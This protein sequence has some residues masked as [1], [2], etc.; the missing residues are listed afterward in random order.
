MPTT[1]SSNVLSDRAQVRRQQVLE[2]AADCFRRRG[3]HGASMAE[4]AKTAEMSPGHIYNLF[5]NKDEVIAA[6]VE[7][8]RDEVIQNIQ[9]TQDADDVVSAMIACV[10]ESMEDTNQISNAALNLEV[11]AEAGRNPK[12][13]AV[14]QD[15][16]TVIRNKA[17]AVIRKALGPA[18]ETLSPH[19]IEARATVV[20]TI[21]NGLMVMSISQPEMNKP[22]VTEVIQ[23]VMKSLAEP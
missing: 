13:A 7:R 12:L 18:A 8:D 15:S 16:E 5:K 17:M 11:L 20:G 2:A 23:R 4:I 9:Q 19:E 22:A 14:V 1:M 6:I 3:F 21:F 10:Q